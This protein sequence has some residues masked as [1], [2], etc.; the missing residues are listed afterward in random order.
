MD[1]LS[2]FPQIPLTLN[3]SDNDITKE[4]YEP[5]LRWASKYDRG[6]GYFT[7]EWIRLNADGLGEF[8]SKGGIVRWITSPILDERD[9]EAL[10]LGI[11]KPDDP[12]FINILKQNVEALQ[13]SLKIDTLHTIAWSDRRRYL[14]VSICAT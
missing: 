11:D 1:Y 3:T 9:F 14:G 13:R 2:E 12:I 5:C 8:A 6:V 4:F 7:S 10:V